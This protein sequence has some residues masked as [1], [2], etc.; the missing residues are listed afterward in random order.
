MSDDHSHRYRGRLAPTPSGLL[1]LGHA[2]TFWIAQQRAEQAGGDLVLRLEDLDR[3]RCKPEY[4]TAI[5]ADLTWLG[6]RWQE[7]PDVG[8]PHAP[9]EQQARLPFYSEIWQQLN[10]A[11]VIY[12]SPHSRRD[13]QQALSAPHEG[14]RELIFPPALRPTAFAAVQEPGAVNWR[15]CVPDGESIPVVDGRLGQVSYK[16]GV[17]FG[18]FLV[19]RKDGFPSYELA[20][21]VDDHAMQISEVVRGED[22]LLSAAKQSLLYHALGWAIPAFYHAPLLRDRQGRRLAK[23][24]QALALRSLRQE[25]VQPATLRQAWASE[26]A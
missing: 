2:R 24:H 14:D 3:T 15:F 19:W 10:A 4:V 11:G 22:L 7:G 13:V 18:D 21:V 20:V 6:L 16:A 25:G 5:Y 8:G 17:D 26:L 12:P 1:H 23:R 9:Y